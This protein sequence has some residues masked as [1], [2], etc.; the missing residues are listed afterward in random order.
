MFKK[1]NLY[2]N[3]NS[4]QRQDAN[5]TLARYL[6]MLRWREGERILDV[7]SGSGNVTTEVLLPYLPNNFK[8]LVSSVTCKHH[9]YTQLNSSEV[10]M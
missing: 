7:G 3:G 2:N 5:R 8:H 1:A 9:S 6:H 4:I 10:S